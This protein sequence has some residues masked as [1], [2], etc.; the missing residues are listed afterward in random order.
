ML[1]GVIAKLLPLIY[2]AFPRMFSTSI[3]LGRMIPAKTILDV[4]C[5]EGGTFNW[6]KR[7]DKLL[8]L[9][10]MAAYTVGLDIYGPSLRKARVYKVYNDVV[11][12]DA[13]F[14][15]FRERSFDV[16]TAF[17]VIEHLAKPY[18]YKC[19]REL[20]RVAKRQVIITTPVMEIIQPPSEYSE[21]VFQK[22]R[23]AWHPEEMKKL[24]F[25]VI[26][27]RGIKKIFGEARQS[28][29][30]YSVKHPLF[31]PL[32]IFIKKMSCLIV[33]YYPNIAH[34]Q[35]CIKMVKD[36]YHD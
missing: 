15:P 27:L 25:K 28:G 14:L 22:H 16:C 35:L 36:E 26:G 3:I 34:Q 17:E 13:R 5:G 8:S 30:D 2:K 7:I 24:G 19:L 12:A 20:N 1:K 4:G 11:N 32:V 18:A 33:Y 6:L 31:K 29:V 10:K 9:N 23:S 21:N